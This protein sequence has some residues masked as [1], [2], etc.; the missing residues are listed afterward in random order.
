MNV[1]NNKNNAQQLTKKKIF[2][3]KISSKVI[4]KNLQKRNSLKTI[5]DNQ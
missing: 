2:K 5:S 3:Y 1:S 4:D